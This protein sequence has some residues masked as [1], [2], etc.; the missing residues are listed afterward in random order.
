MSRRTEDS[1]KIVTQIDGRAD[2]ISTRDSVIYDSDGDTL[3]L[4]QTEPPVEA[5]M[6]NQEVVVTYVVQ[7]ESGYVRYGFYAV[8]TDFLDDFQPEPGRHRRA[9]TVRRRSRP[10]PYNIRMRYRVQPSNKSGLD[11]SVRGKKVNVVDISLGGIR[12]S[13]DER[14]RLEVNKVVEVGLAVGRDVHTVEA[15]IVRIWEKEAEFFKTEVRL[16]AAEFR[17]MSRRFE[18]ELSRKIREIER[19]R[20]S[21]I[22]E[23]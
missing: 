22:C 2:T 15:R 23:I 14:L 11:V 21:I 1:V 6:L 12:F 20:P 18:D 10:E 3:I 5:S 19:E 13:Y 16:A 4:A 8:I 9:I 7:E 17:N